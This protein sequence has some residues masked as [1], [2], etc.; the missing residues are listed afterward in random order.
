M[1]AQ[2]EAEVPPVDVR[3]QPDQLKLALDYRVI[4][5]LFGGGVKP[6]EPDP[7]S[8]IRV[9]SIVGQLR[10]WWRACRGA[11]CLSIE[12]LRN[13]EDAI[14]GSMSRPSEVRLSLGRSKPGQ[15][16]EPF[17]NDNGRS[18]SDDRVAP[19][20]VSFPMQ[21]NR[22]RYQ[23]GQIPAKVHLDVEFQLVIEFPSR[24]ESDI[25]AAVWAWSLFGGVGARTRRG[26]GALQL[27]KR[28][29]QL[30]PLVQLTSLSRSIQDGLR[31]Y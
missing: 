7:V 23:P 26:F 15:P 6:Q 1:R 2:P 14:W 13:R 3:P 21:P 5:P 4:T 27:L 8:T 16:A 17:R 9:A 31:R 18:S 30:E 28:N 12:E 29:G 10:F 20:Y 24:L 19:P 22:G 11:D 25:E